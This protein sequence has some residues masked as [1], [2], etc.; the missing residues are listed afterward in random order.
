LGGLLTL[1]NGTI[2]VYFYKQKIVGNL[3]YFG[4]IRVNSLKSQFL[5]E[6]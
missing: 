6:K 5:N 4:K 1:E 2:G 3:P